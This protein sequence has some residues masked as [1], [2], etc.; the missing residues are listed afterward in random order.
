MN[1]ET[2]IVG[3]FGGAIWASIAQLVKLGKE[4]THHKQD[5]FDENWELKKRIQRLEQK[6]GFK[7]RDIQEPFILSDKFTYEE[8]CEVA[9]KVKK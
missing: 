8:A 5:C 6:L 9:R 2:I 4:L 3:V 1:I 7:M